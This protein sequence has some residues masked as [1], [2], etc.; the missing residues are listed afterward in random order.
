MIMRR[1]GIPHVEYTLTFDNGEPY[2]LCENFI[3]PTTELI[4]A[5]RVKEAFKQDNRDSDFVHLLRCCDELEIPNVRAA[6]NKMLTLD[7]IISNEDRHYNNFG[8]VRDAET[9]QWQGLAPIY[10]SG[11]SLWYNTRFVGRAMECKPF[12][13]DHA[14][15]IE[16][17]DDLSWF[18][19]DALRDGGGEFMEV[20]SWSENVDDERRTALAAAIRERCEQVERMKRK[21]L[22]T[23]D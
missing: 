11:T 4:S 9:L 6:L 13:K 2:S 3:T 20:F 15:Q 19:D 18:N 1:L 7:Y 16:L 12:K 23:P 10:D 8:F 5:W 21:R 17:A 22:T 14:A